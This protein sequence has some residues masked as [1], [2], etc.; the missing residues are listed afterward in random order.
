MKR[1]LRAFLAPLAAAMLV[2][3]GQ[4]AALATT[5]SYNAAWYWIRAQADGQGTL[6]YTQDNMTAFS[7][8]DDVTQTGPADPWGLHNTGW[9]GVRYDLAKGSVGAFAWAYNNRQFD[10]SVWDYRFFDNATAAA[11]VGVADD[12][13]FTIPAGSYP[14]PLKVTISGLVQGEMVATGNYS[15][16]ATYKASLG[17]PENRA[18]PKVWSVNQGSFFD[19]AHFVNNALNV[20]ELF[21]LEA[22]LLKPGTTLLESKTVGLRL[23]LLLGDGGTISAYTPVLWDQRVQGSARSMFGN[24]MRIY[25]LDVPD[26]VTW[27]SSSGVFLSDIQPIPE[28]SEALLM[29]LGLLLVTVITRRQRS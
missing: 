10:Y 6:V 27:T 14:D 21:S 15:V 11:G 9:A 22:T 28:P 4:T 3:G 1:E 7:F 25:A 16:H 18:V 2:A 17:A 12:L 24:T 29:S 26:G 13:Y 8:E 5:T 19:G 20:N 23:G